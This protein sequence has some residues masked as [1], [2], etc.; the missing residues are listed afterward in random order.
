MALQLTDLQQ[1]VLT[2]FAINAVGNSAPVTDPT[3]SVT[4]D[5]LSIEPDTTHGMSA[6]FTTG[7]VCGAAQVMFTCKAGEKELSAT[8]DIDVIASEATSV[9]IIAEE[10]RPKPL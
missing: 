7:T 8:F 2:A 10:P 6:L 5:I 9:L 3:W 1:V 4:P